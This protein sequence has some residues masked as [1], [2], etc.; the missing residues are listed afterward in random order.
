MRNSIL[1]WVEN[2]NKRR[3]RAVAGSWKAF[4][5]SLGRT[6]S[7]FILQQESKKL[8]TKISAG[9]EN[10]SMHN[11]RY[12]VQTSSHASVKNPSCA[13]SEHY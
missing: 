5:V 12:S 4:N 13:E 7:N 10:Y 11:L 2:F 3:F 9:F 1:T 6:K 8:D